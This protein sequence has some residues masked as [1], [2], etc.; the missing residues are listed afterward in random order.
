MRLSYQHFQ[1]LKRLNQNPE[2]AKNLSYFY[3]YCNGYKALKILEENRFIEK[4][5]KFYYITEKGKIQLRYKYG[6]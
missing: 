6:I 1:I 3:C 4:R 5:G 2:S